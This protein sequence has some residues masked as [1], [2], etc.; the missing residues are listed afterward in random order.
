MG[1]EIH[2]CIKCGNKMEIGFFTDFSDSTYTP[3]SWRG[4]TYKKTFM[5]QFINDRSNDINISAYRCTSCGFLELYA[6]DKKDEDEKL[7]PMNL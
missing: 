4:G 5:N 1:T 2:K 6:I 7:P 3:N